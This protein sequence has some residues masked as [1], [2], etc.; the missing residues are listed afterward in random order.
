MVWGPVPVYCAAISA[1][2]KAKQS[3]KALELPEEMRQKSRE[4]NVITY[5]TAISA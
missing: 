1:W 2:K 5:C 4:P 3:L